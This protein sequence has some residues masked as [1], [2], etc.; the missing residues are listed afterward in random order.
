M[1]TNFMRFVSVAALGILIFVAPVAA[2][3]CES[4]ASLTLPD[5]KITSAALIAAGAFTP[6]TGGGM[7]MGGSGGQSAFKSAPA[8]CRVTATLTPTPDSDIRIEVWMP[9]ENWNGKLVGTG[10]GIW[11]GSISYSALAEPLAKGYATVATDAGHI[12]SGMDA[13]FAVGHKEKLIDFG[14]RAVHEMTVKAKAVIAAYYGRKEQRSLWVSCSTGGRQGLMEAYRYPEDYNGISSMAPAN[15]M[16][17]LMIGSLWTGYAAIKDDAHRLSMAKLNAAHK[18]F[19]NQCDEKDGLKDGIVGDPEHCSFDPGT[20]QCK[21]GDGNDCLT[22]PQVEA[23]RDIYAGTKNPR[24][25]EKIFAGFEPGSEPQL[26]TLVS[27]KEPFPVATSYFR[28]VVLN[29]PQWDY[30][31][32]D[33]DKDLAASYKAGSDIVDVPSNGLAKFFN[34]GG[35]L[36]LSHGWSDGLIPASNTAAFY[37]SMT[38]T[39]DPKKAAASTRL[40]MLPGVGH[41]GGGDGPSVTDMLSVIDQWVET[42]K[43]PDRIIASNPPNQKPMTRPLCPYPQI[44][45]YKGSGSTDDA[46]NFE[47]K[48]R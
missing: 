5:G 35:R 27:G 25:G 37:K 24:T 3:S 33:Y 18:A 31:S 34:G 15:P 32:Y 9:A 2:A 17:G 19:I 39:M 7:M 47:C 26:M 10:N 46:A 30:K 20:I 45:K 14:Y 22:A 40:F 43:A 1:L 42:G 8:F 21:E 41:C 16:V 6:P 29:N 13:K 48:A 28:D 12:G 4:L 23:L 11:A 38:A 36:L 44:A